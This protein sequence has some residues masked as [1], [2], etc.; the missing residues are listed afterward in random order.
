MSYSNEDMEGAKPHELRMSCTQKHTWA[1]L[2]SGLDQLPQ[3]WGRT[4]R[5]A[6]W[7]IRGPVLKHS[8]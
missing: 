3:S 4:R 1:L 5:K 8:Y 7:P 2:G 6:V